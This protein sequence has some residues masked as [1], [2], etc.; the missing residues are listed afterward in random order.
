MLSHASAVPPVRTL[1]IAVI[2]APLGGRLMFRRRLAECQPSS[3]GAARRAAVPLT[4]VAGTTDEELGQA[5]LANG[6]AKKGRFARE[7]FDGTWASGWNAIL[8]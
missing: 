4:A 2:K 8:T 3:L 6:V 5:P 1:S 7:V